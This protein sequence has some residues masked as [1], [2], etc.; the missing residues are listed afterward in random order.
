MVKGC[1][2]TASMALPIE[3]LRGA[4]LANG[5]PGLT[6]RHTD[7]LEGVV[8]CTSRGV[9]TRICEVFMR[10]RP[11][12]TWGSGTPSVVSFLLEER[13]PESHLAAFSERL[14]VPHP[15]W[16][17]AI[18]EHATWGY[19]QWLWMAAP[20]LVLGLYNRAACGPLQG[21][22]HRRTRNKIGGTRCPH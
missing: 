22:P 10:G 3:R 6:F 1:V 11:E 18:D 17:T 20:P 19:G 12:G 15:S 8:W 16:L 13:F 7:D 4:G 9:P 14:R 21:G 5:Q 2:L